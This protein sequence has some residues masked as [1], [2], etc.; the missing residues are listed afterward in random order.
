MSKFQGFQLRAAP[1]AAAFRFVD[2]MLHG[3]VEAAQAVVSSEAEET[4]L[5]A[6]RQFSKGGPVVPAE[7]EEE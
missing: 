2:R 6:G 4:Q 1:N 3:D 5:A 7:P